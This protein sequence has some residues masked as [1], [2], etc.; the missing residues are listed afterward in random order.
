MFLLV[1]YAAFLVGCL[2]VLY[3][4]I[5]KAV[6]HGILDAEQARRDNES[7]QRL[8]ATLSKSSNQDDRL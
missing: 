3:M 4:V 1:L 7:L 6:H 8:R 2:F 5:R